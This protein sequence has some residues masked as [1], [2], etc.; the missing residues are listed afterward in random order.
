MKYRDRERGFSL[1]SSMAALAILT[2][3]I[4]GTSTLVTYLV[5][6]SKHSQRLNLAVSVNSQVEAAIM[7]KSQYQ[8]TSEAGAT[9]RDQQ[10]VDMADGKAAAG[11]VLTAK[12]QRKDGGVEREQIMPV[13]IIGARLPFDSEGVP[14]PNE[15]ARNYPMYVESQMQC[16]KTFGCG[17]AYRVVLQPIAGE[18]L[19]SALG[20]PLSQASVLAAAFNRPPVFGPNDYDLQLPYDFIKQKQFPSSCTAGTDILISGLSRTTGAVACLST[21]ITPCPADQIAD[22]LQAVGGHFEMTC[23]PISKVQCP[24]D[25]VLQNYDFSQLDPVTG[26][27]GGIASGTHGTCVYRWKT[28]IPWQNPWPHQPTSSAST[29]SVAACNATVYDAVAPQPCIAAPLQYNDVQ[30]NY[31]CNCSTDS[32]GNTTCATCTRTARSSASVTA[33]SIDPNTNVATCS[34]QITDDCGSSMIAEPQWSGTCEV[35][36][37]KVNASLVKPPVN[38]TLQ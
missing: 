12:V 15:D 29:A 26:A 16:G 36:E 10:I 33:Q 3:V 28:H 18:L 31:A 13:A 23:H 17:V 34:I 24:T 2:T 32:K 22:G 14:H 21:A 8:K 35:R 4:A 19:P 25:Y 5:N 7:D 9:D 27:P 1:V 38:G 37:R 20:A 30:C 6:E 11:F